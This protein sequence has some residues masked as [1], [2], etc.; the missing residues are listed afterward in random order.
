MIRIFNQY[1]SAKALLLMFL[2]DVL[3][4]LSLLIGARLRFWGEPA[5]FANYIQFPEFI[6]QVLTVVIIFQASLYY[7][8]LYNLSLMRRRPELLISLGQALGAGTV[9]VGL[10]Y[11]LFPTLLIG[12][13]VFFIGMSLLVGSIVLFRVTLDHAWQLAAPARTVLIMGTR[14]M[15]VTVARELLKRDDLNMRL[16]GFLS[17]G[18]GAPEELFGCRVYE[19]GTQLESLVQEHR[20]GRIIVALEDQRG[21]LPIR[22]LV[23]LRVQGIRIDDAHSTV[24]ALTGRVWLNSVKPSWF[25][26][27]DGFHRARPALALK[28]AFDLTF[29]L[30]GLILSLPIMAAV[31]III[32]LDS[33]GDII[34][35]QSRV[36]LGGTT[37]NVLKFR[38][39]RID[40]EVGTGA[41]WASKND[42]RVTTVGRYL[43]K[44]RFDELPQFINVIRGE[45]SF[46]GP[47]PERPVF[48]DQLRKQISYYDERH[49][50]RPGL[51]G[52]AQ[53]QYPYGASVEDSFRKLEY[54]LFYLQNMSIIFDAAILFQTVR[55]VLTGRGA[56]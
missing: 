45:M 53:V 31:A 50:V 46:V 16:A 37:F 29:A 26:F 44:F 22:D 1:V 51:T 13:G 21:S 41:Q 9:I 25:V 36:G 30:L 20:I 2:E 3:I 4:A 55:T 6:L 8:D 18:A 5:E 34:Y 7:S 48:V 12:R 27:S 10:V 33:K 15:A 40:A 32:R 47:R 43:R 54:D 23:K 11:Y 52:W 35:R 17:E 14:Q 42:P 24:A 19:P 39:M 56:Q 28:R 38:S 49:S